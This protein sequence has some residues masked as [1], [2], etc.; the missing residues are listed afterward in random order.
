[1]ASGLTPWYKTKKHRH[2]LASAPTCVEI[3]TSVTSKSSA[4]GRPGR[5]GNSMNRLKLTVNHSILFTKLWTRT[6][7]FGGLSSVL[8]MCIEEMGR[9]GSLH[10]T[11]FGFVCF[12]PLFL[13][14]LNDGNYTGPSNQHQLSFFHLLS[15]HSRRIKWQ[16]PR[17]GK[18]NFWVYWLENWGSVL[19]I[20]TRLS[21]ETHRSTHWKGA[22]STT[23]WF[24]LNSENNTLLWLLLHYILL[25][26]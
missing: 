20:S 16:R 19:L 3:S 7:N 17:R 24:I 14:I 11:L 25:R 18:W 4:C 13:E 2:L 10:M 23:R 22:F 6:W 9:G 5:S 1:M 15:I 26:K 21:S 12:V 8:C